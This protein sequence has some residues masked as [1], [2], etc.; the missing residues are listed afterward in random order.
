MIRTLIPEQTSL[1]RAGLV[2]FLSYVAVL[3]GTLPVIDGFAAA[4]ALH[5]QLPTWHS[6]I[7][8]ERRPTR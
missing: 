4:C 2:A 1:I 8:G 7:M 5:A 3:A 6:L